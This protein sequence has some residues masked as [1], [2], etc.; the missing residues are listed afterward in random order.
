MAKKKACP[1]CEEGAPLWMTTYGD[2]VTLMLCLFVM[3]FA[4]GKS[5]PQEVQL[6][7][8]AFNNSMGF[9]TGGQ[10]LSKG[11]MEEMG[12][13]LESLPSQTRGRSLSRAKQQAQSVFVP[14]IQA[15]KVRITEDERG[16]VISLISADFFRPGSALP[17]A[18]MEEVLEKVA[19][20]V[21]SLNRFVRVEGY[22]AVGEEQRIGPAQSQTAAGERN[23]QNSW[24]LAGARAINATAFLVSEGAPPEFI[25]AVSYG[26]YRPLADGRDQ[27]TPEADANNRRIDI[28]IMTNK[29]ARR[30][31]GESGFRLPETPLPGADNLVPEN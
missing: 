8:S 6:I 18:E 19:P 29:D 7:L 3:I 28:V 11:R 5:T 4:T 1:P 9:F 2:M 27:G 17:T 10:T 12:M 21:K 13:N 14:E 25:Q 15:R 22:A 20:L 30:D 24:D 31:P 23:Y 16:L 26:Q